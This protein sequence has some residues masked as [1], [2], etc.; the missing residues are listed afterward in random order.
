[1]CLTANAAVGDILV[2]GDPKDALQVGEEGLR[3]D[4]PEMGV[5]GLLEVR[6]SC[7]SMWKVAVS[8]RKPLFRGKMKG[9][10]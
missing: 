3:C 4:H 8:I 6:V 5:N 9:L 2:P 7:L 10:R 1:M